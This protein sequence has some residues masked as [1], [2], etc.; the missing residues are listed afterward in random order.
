MALPVQQS[1]LEVGG[2]APM[3]RSARWIDEVMLGEI[4][5]WVCVI[6]AMLLGALMLIDQ[7]PM[8]EGAWVV[9]GRT[10]VLSAPATA[11][12]IV[13]CRTETFEREA[14]SIIVGDEGR[15]HRVIGP[16]GSFNPYARPSLMKELKPRYNSKKLL[17]NKDKIRRFEKSLPL[18]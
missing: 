14:G 7:L 8:R 3:M 5:L 4:A 1:L 18:I 17:E 15:V 2:G 16:L 6:A 9:A 10:S 11:T 13:M 12:G